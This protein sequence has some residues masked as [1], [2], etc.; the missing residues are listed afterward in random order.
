M[1]GD[2]QSLGFGGL[3]GGLENGDVAT[4]R[5]AAE[6]DAYYALGTV[7]ECEVND[8]EGSGEVITAVYGE[9][10]IRFHGVGFIEC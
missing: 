9:D 10:E 2:F 5:I 3:E 6:I 4:G 7:F 8:G 1:D